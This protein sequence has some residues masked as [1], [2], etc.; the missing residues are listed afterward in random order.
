MLKR[1]DRKKDSM[2]KSNRVK[3]GTATQR[4]RPARVSADDPFDLVRAQPWYGTRESDQE[5]AVDID[6]SDTTYYV[7]ADIPGASREDIDVAIAGDRVTITAK[8][9]L[10]E[11][12]LKDVRPVVRERVHGTR[13]RRIFLDAEVDAGKAVATFRDGVLNLDLPKKPG[14]RGRSI[15]IG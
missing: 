14:A 11:V 1:N 4:A 3:P 5:I 9:G 8:V 12:E 6:E 15:A 10:V 13:S 2:A 7:K